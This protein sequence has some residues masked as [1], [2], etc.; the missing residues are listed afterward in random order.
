MASTS[1]AV[2]VAITGSATDLYSNPGSVT[3]QLVSLN[4]TNTTTSDI[5]VDVWFAPTGGGTLVYLAD[6][7]TVPA[8]GEAAWAGMGVSSAS[9]DK[10]R[11]QASAVGVDCIGAVVESS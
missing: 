10:W 9:G 6:D 2:N 11:A 4:L 8:K 1:K 5:T 3:A 7:L